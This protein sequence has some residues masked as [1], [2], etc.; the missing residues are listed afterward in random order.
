MEIFKKEIK[1][2]SIIKQKTMEVAI[3]RHISKK[4][5]IIEKEQ[6]KLTQ[7]KQLHPRKNSVL[8]GDIDIGNSTLQ[9]QQ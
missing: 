4:L 1:N 6:Q 8:N 7:P 5:S 3:T 2:M 9:L